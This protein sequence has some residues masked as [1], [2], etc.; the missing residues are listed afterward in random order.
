MNPVEF[1]Y[2]H[3]DYLQM[4]IE[5]GIP[6]TL[7]LLTSLLLFFKSSYK[8]L[9]IL[10]AAGENLRF[11][12]GL[13]A[14][15]GVVAILIHSLTD[16]NLHI[17]SNAAYFAVLLG[18]MGAVGNIDKNILNKSEKISDVILETNLTKPRIRKKLR[19]K[20]ISEE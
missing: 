9:T 19:K 7:F 3:N 2:A 6:A 17:P 10:Y 12:L 5:T 8:N 16:F 13:G 14:M 1:V 11:Y 20:I 4:I 15:S 18:I